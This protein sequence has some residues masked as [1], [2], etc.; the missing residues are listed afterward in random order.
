MKMT[1]PVVAIC[2]LLCLSN[3]S[4]ADDKQ[5]ARLKDL[6]KSITSL[7]KRLATRDKEKS[8]LQS[9]LKKVEL[10]AGKISRDL[11][12][13]R[14][15]ISG[16]ESK[17]SKL[18]KQETALEENIALQSGAIVDQISAAYKLGN[19]EPIKLLLNQE[20]PQKMARVFKYYG[21]FLQA[22]TE[23]IQNYMA[24]VDALSEVIES[25]E[26]R[27]STPLT[28]GE[29]RSPHRQTWSCQLRSDLSIPLAS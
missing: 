12:K 9:A 6:E 18:N 15:N 4:I 26:M 24:D 3:L 29:T 11:R 5:Q 23:K 10:E 1:R 14:K 19:Q 27:C 16:L 20:E 17:L 2:L 7:E 22:R 21:Y 28:T 13:L 25:T 8:N